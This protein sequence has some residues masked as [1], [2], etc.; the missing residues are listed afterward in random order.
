[1]IYLWKNIKA[2]LS[3]PRRLKFLLE[4]EAYVQ[5]TEFGACVFTFNGKQLSGLHDTCEKAIDEACEL[6]ET[7][8]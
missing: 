3:A 8:V 2:A 4:N 6:M 5:Q 7:K 1:M